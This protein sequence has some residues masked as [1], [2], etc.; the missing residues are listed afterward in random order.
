MKDRNAK[1][2]Q[3]TTGWSYT[4]CLR[5]VRELTPDQILDL[6]E[7]RSKGAMPLSLFRRQLAAEKGTDHR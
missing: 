6:I 3:K 7:E 2:L 1:R 4:E 5:C